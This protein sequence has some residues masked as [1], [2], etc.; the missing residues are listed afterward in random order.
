MIYY[1]NLRANVVEL[2]YERKKKYENVDMYKTI[3]KGI[4]RGLDLLYK[5]D[6]FVW[7]ICCFR[8]LGEILEDVS[9]TIKNNVYVSV[10]LPNIL[11]NVR[12]Q[13]LK[14]HI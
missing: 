1:L 10:V 9:E 8:E 6:H 2:L 5:F 11:F 12:L 14:A 7:F 3:S 4:N 13:Y